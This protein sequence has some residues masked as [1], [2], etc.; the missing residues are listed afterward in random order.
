MMIIAKADLNSKYHSTARLV[1][2]DTVLEVAFFDALGLRNGKI[3]PTLRTFFSKEDFIT[4]TEEGKWLQGAL[5]SMREYNIM[6]YYTMF[7]WIM[8][9]IDTEMSRHTIWSWLSDAVQTTDDPMRM[10][11]SFQRSVRERKY[12][13]RRRRIEGKIDSEMAEFKDPPKEFEK[14]VYSRILRFS[15]YL[16]Y[17]PDGSK[18]LIECSVCHKQDIV[19]RKDVE[20]KAKMKRK[21]PMCGADC[22]CLPKRKIKAWFRDEKWVMYIDRKK[23]KFAL[24]YFEASR[25]YKNGIPKD[26]IKEYARE[27]FLAKDGYDKPQSYEWTWF[28]NH[29][30]VRWC[31][32]TNRILC[33]RT[34]LYTRNLP[35]ALRGTPYEYTAMEL[36]ARSDR[37]RVFHYEWYMK[38][39]AQ[40]TVMERL[41]KMGQTKLVFKSEEYSGRLDNIIDWNRNTVYEQ[42]RLSK[43][44]LKTFVRINGDA[45]QL[46]VLQIATEKGIEPDEN[47]FRTMFA[48]LGNDLGRLYQETKPGLTPNRLFKW[49]MK[50]N[51]GILEVQ[52]TRYDRTPMQLLLA[53]WVDYIGWCK[54]LNKNLNDKS[55]LLPKGFATAHDTVCAEYRADIDKKEAEKKK[56]QYENVKQAMRRTRKAM[57]NVLGE[58]S[59]FEN[60]KQVKGNGLVFVLPKKAEDLVNE[61]EVLHHCVRTYIDRVANG[62]TIIIFIRKLDDMRTPFYTMEWRNGRVIQ[63][64]GMRNCDMTDEVR[65]AVRAF[66]KKMQSVA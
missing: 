42:L 61:S 1:L 56:A 32:G 15:Q 58:N 19:R 50:E 11:I 57:E 10:I 62:E 52:H 6:P 27:V 16:F 40:S 41:V 48:E 23:D 22:T 63:C 39:A 45:G 34:T 12:A 51:G 54:H 24:R 26:S 53:D 3:S 2:D 8:P 21:C 46:K 14:F 18:A 35:R 33:G 47:E 60:S 4:L 37:D 29:G 55:V 31:Q 64:R 9:T 49:L 59:E 17:T 36:L 66:E 44:N 30:N 25:E 13:E 38:K 43:A 28:R 20:L 5:D 7:S 65:E